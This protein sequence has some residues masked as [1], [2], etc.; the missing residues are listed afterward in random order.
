[1]DV[2]VDVADADSDSAMGAGEWLSVLLLI[3]VDVVL[4]WPLRGLLLEPVLSTH[5]CSSDCSVKG[6]NEDEVVIAAANGDE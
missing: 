4:G 5:V 2:D 3:L 6:E 1:M